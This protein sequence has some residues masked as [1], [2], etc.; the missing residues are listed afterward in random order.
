LC[1]FL[2][3]PQRRRQSTA[4]R[5]GWVLT[6]PDNDPRRH[7]LSPEAS[8]GLTYLEDLAENAAERRRLAPS[9]RAP[10]RLTV[11]T[12]ARE[13]GCSR[14]EIYRLMKQARIEL[15]GKEL[16]DSAIY[17]RLRRDR[18]HGDP[19]ARPCAHEGCPRRLPTRA[20][21]RRRY[22]AF[23]LAPHARTARHRGRRHLEA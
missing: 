6:I 19:A 3:V 8:T 4:A 23:H 10:E 17:H 7:R 20:T 13:D 1:Y 22:C 11:A 5:Y 9:G 18:V 12:M 16:S 21:A 15:F 2:A 14:S